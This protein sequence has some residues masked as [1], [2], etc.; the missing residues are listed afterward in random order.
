[1]AP[2]DDCTSSTT[3]RAIFISQDGS[4]SYSFEDIVNTKDCMTQ[5]IQQIEETKY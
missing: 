5:T 1:M 2:R 4:A 3:S